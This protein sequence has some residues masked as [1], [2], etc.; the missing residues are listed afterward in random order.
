MS[1]SSAARS[2][3]SVSSYPAP[4]SA[5]IPAKSSARPCPAS[6]S[7]PAPR[8]A[9]PPGKA[10]PPP[11][12]PDPPAHALVAGKARRRPA[13]LHDHVADRGPLGRRERRDAGSR[14]LED[15]VQPAAHPA[16]AQQL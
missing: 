2:I 6:P 11:P 9:R 7:P 8:A 5:A 10:A 15:A 14:E 13:G 3:T 1:G 16:A 12:P 4:S